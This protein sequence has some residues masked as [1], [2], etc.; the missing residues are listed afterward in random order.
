[1]PEGTGRPGAP[2]GPAVRW[3][4]FAAVA[5]LSFVPFLPSLSNGFV[6]WDDEYNFTANARYR[7]LSP[8]HLAWMFSDTEGHYM[9]FTWITLG[10]DYTLWGMD[11][12]GYH[13]TSM[14][15]HALNGALFFLVLARLLRRA[16][17]GAEPVTLHVAAA[18]GALFFALHPLRVESVTWVTE[19]RDVVSGLFFILSLLAYLRAQ[20]GGGR[21]L[22]ILS[23][24]LF[25]ASL[26]SK[27]TGMMLPL[28]LLAL[29][30]W[31]LR[32]FA[33]GA[34]RPVLAEKIPYAALALGAV[35]LT[36]VTQSHAGAFTSAG[37]YPLHE[38]VLQPGYRFLFYLWK[39]LVPLD[40]SPIYLYVPGRS[41]QGPLHAICLLAVVAATALLVRRRR[42]WPALLGAWACCGFLLSPVLG[43]LQAGPHFAADRYTYLPGLAWA[44]LAG[45]GVALLR[46]ARL[47]GKLPTAG[48]A[49]CVAGVVAALAAFSALTWNQTKV[50]KDS[51]TLWEHAVRLDAANYLAFH[52]RGVSRRERKDAAGALADC[53]EALRLNPRHAN[54]YSHRA[55]L[56]QDRGDLEGAIADYTTALEI[57]RAGADTLN[58]RGLARHL[59]GDVAGAISDFDQALALNPRH[60]KALANRA[61]AR[62]ARGDLDGCLADYT[63]AL[64]FEP[65][66]DRILAHR[67]RARLKKGDLEGA[68]EDLERAIQANPESSEALVGRG[69]WKQGRGDLNGALEDYDRA[70]RSDP[71][72]AD[73][74]GN[75]GVARHLKGDLGGA[76]ADYDA[77]VRLNPKYMMAWANRGMARQSRGD[78]AGAIADY[79][80]ALKLDPLHV[81]SWA[82]RAS[83]RQA[84]GD[85]EGALSDYDEALRLNPRH[86]EA[87]ANRGGLRARKGD[88]AG[89]LSDFRKCLEA[90]P[91]DWPP[92]ARVEEEIR[93]L[94]GN[95]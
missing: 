82:H 85:V 45:G 41:T 60:A 81:D 36:W 29:D 78:V 12:T 66:T 17:A 63:E 64:R 65:R 7:G 94:S 84:A 73:A 61:A 32:R 20:D 53:E 86:A 74:L 37:A 67:G 70:A 71:A 90:A 21:R 5:A 47:E 87:Y 25:G 4:L 46:R 56:R 42:R 27:T 76:I 93:K 62:Q 89:A 48:F 58:N 15:F 18:V 35:A 16:G 6:N 44:A 10:L 80:E 24:V 69:L 49:G 54:A 95:P 68:I 23:V 43:V 26:L 8:A 57:E 40:L 22:R 2:P 55:L 11:T 75:R 9:P 1:M 3:G 91:A 51:L 77:A 72:S 14:V 83:A 59:Q 52:N 28:V 33:G 39:T 79:G 13:L 92:R 50:W 34:W 38:V 30:A 31:P 19:R 88:R